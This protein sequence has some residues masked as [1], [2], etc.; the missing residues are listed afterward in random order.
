MHD[1]PDA[2]MLLAHRGDLSGRKAH[3]DGTMSLPQDHLC[4]PHLI[5]IEAA[6]NLVGIPD[7][8]VV[9]RDAHLERSVPA[10]VL[11]WQEEH[12]LAA[13]ECPLQRRRGVRRGADRAAALAG[14]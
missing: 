14:E 6:K 9:E 13:L 11:V 4:A 12:L 1:H 8:H 10:E 5:R 7:D 3:V 2:W